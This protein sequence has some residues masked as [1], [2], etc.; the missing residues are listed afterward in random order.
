MSATFNPRNMYT[1]GVK[2]AQVGF[3]YDKTLFYRMRT[4]TIVGALSRASKKVDSMYAGAG[5]SLDGQGVIVRKE[6][7]K[8]DLVRYTMQEHITG[9]PTYGD[10]IPQRG[11][12]LK[13]KNTDARVNMITSPATPVQ[14]EMDQ[15]R[16][17]HSI[18]NIPGSVREE[19]IDWSAEEYER[20][21]I[22]GQLYGASPSVLLPETEGGLG[23]TLGVGAGAGAG[24]PLMTKNFW[25]PDTGYVAYDST[26]ATY[27]TAVNNAV[28][29]IDPD[30]D[31]MLSLVLLEQIVAGYDDIKIWAPTINGKKY[32]ALNL[33][34]PALYYRLNNLL[35]PYYKDALERGKKNPLFNYADTIEFMDCLFIS[36]PNLKK[37]RM[38]YNSTNGYP[39]I[40][41]GLRTDHRNYT[42]TSKNAIML[43]LGARSTLE[44]YDGSIK[45]K[46]DD[47]RFGRGAEYISETQ[48]GFTR[49][50]FYAKDGT[51][52]ADACVNHGSACQLFYEPGVGVNYN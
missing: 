38:A 29:G 33:L 3:D 22:I 34:D 2:D 48:C 11:N 36:M 7:T 43:T 5:P 25:T 37:F 28:N 51:T 41:P 39:D 47:G 13:W 1:S 42:T 14:G 23:H 12:F 26:A 40:G 4:R 49:T 15:K 20:Q 8:G 44:G 32:K 6:I 35:R 10:T 9:T 46:M 50:E 24:T 27:N 17:A 16:V 30:P 21:F 18:T 45:V 19:V 31:D 52:G